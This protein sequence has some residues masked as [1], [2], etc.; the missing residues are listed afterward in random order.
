MAD[1][2]RRLETTLSIEERLKQ[3]REFRYGRPGPQGETVM[4][5][6][7]KDPIRRPPPRPADTMESG[8][9]SSTP[10]SKEGASAE[11]EDASKKK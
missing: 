8:N 11:S 7:R 1:R 9:S 3:Y 6:W 10:L 4:N 5:G 2:R